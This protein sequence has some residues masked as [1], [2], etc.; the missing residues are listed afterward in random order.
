MDL[1][2]LYVNQFPVNDLRRDR[3]KLFP[4]M[5]MFPTIAEALTL[6]GEKLAVD[7]ALL[8]GEHGTYPRNAKGQT[9]WPRYKFFKQIVDVY[10]RS[11]RTAR[12]LATS[13]CL[14]SGG[15]LRRWSTRRG[16]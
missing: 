11:G 15:G 1:F 3:A 12:S 14:G 2:S 6:G 5:K 9:M 8:I 13:T 7:G 4:S 16:R 10:R